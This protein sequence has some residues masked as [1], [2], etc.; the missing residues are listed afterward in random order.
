M[1]RS[2]TVVQCMITGH[3]FHGSIPHGGLT[4]EMRTWPIIWG[5]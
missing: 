2:S 1:W 3:E 5:W 4:Q